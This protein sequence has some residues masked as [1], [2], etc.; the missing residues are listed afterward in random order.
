MAQLLIMV[1]DNPALLNRVL[2]A[3]TEAGVRGITVL[4]STGVQRLRSQDGGD[5]PTF[6]G[7][8][9]VARTEQ[10]S[11]C[12]LF[13]VTDAKTVRRVVPATE[14]VVGDLNAPD[15]GILFTQPVG[16]VWGLDKFYPSPPDAQ[17]TT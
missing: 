12:T 13:S 1:L 2:E 6:L 17:E 8:R 16:E 14:A 7:F 4:D 10:Y 5:L 15:T 11:H 3:W 9:R